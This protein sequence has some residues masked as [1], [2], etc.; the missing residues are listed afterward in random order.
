MKIKSE[1][2]CGSIMTEKWNGNKY[3]YFR[4]YEEGNQRKWL[5]NTKKNDGYKFRGAG[6]T[7]ITGRTIYT[8][9]SKFVSDKKI[10]T[11]GADYI[12]KHKE[13]WWTSAVFFWKY[14]TGLISCAKKKSTTV[15]EIT[16]II[17]GG[18]N[19]LK[20]RQEYYKKCKEVFK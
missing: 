14:K 15:S 13:Y 18:T 20:E 19:G 2:G 8:E 12:K 6:C 11:Q 10:K 4:K 1:C 9:F 3:E 16:K 17:N 5:G 7:Q